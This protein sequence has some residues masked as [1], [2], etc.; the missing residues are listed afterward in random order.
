MPSAP[1]R[2]CTRGA[3]TA[4]IAFAFLTLLFGCSKMADEPPTVDIKPAGTQLSFRQ[5]VQPIFA[6]YGCP[7]CHGGTAGLTVGTVANLLAGGNHGPAIKPGKA[8]SS[9][10]VQK[11][12]TAPPFGVRMPQGG[13]YLPDATVNQIRVWIDQGAK[14][15]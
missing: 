15:N 13:P 2:R 10:L 12:S 3:F 1:Y 6:A 7:T 5:D 8:D 9:I 4:L 14:D 11:L